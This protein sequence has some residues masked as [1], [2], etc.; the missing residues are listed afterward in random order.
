[1]LGMS[2]SVVP[3]QITNQLCMNFDLK[4]QLGKGQKHGRK[5]DQKRDR[6]VANGEIWSDT[7]RKNWP[8]IDLAGNLTKCDVLIQC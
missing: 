2:F 4:G 3:T 6:N 5:R 1:M 8:E 7:R